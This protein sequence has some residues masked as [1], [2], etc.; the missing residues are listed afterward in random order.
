MTKVQQS[1]DPHH[2]ISIV[3]GCQEGSHEPAIVTEVQL[4]RDTSPVYK[5]YHHD[6]SAPRTSPAMDISSRHACC[7]SLS[8]IGCNSGSGGPVQLALQNNSNRAPAT[9]TT[10]E[11]TSSEIT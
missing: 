8:V 7:H 11:H 2:M 6:N 10:L 1:H 4:S 9:M 5:Q 3:A